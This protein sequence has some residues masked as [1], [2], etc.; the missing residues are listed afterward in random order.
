MADA[1]ISFVTGIFTISPVGVSVGFGSV[2]TLYLA[3]QNCGLVAGV[4]ICFSAEIGNALYPGTDADKYIRILAPLIPI[5]Y[6]DTAT[7]AMMKGLGEQVY[8]MKI[9]VADAAISVLLVWLLIPHY[10]ID[11]YVFAIYFSEI[12]NTVFSITHLLTVASPHVS[13]LGWV[14]KPLF[15]IVAS[16]CTV[17]ALLSILPVH[18]PNAAL[19][20]TVHCLASTLLY[21]LLLRLTGA[22]NREDVTWMRG[23]LGKE[24]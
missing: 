4:M 24:S 14:Y 6:V 15:C 8:S 22:L 5:M 20:I 16:T 17:R 11:G 13:L 23:L 19:S 1:V 21:V 2:N 10:G 12:F 9:N 18:I 3:V 7:D